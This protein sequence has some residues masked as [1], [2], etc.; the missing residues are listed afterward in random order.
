[1]PSKAL[2]YLYGLR[3]RYLLLCHKRN[4]RA[5]SKVANSREN[6]PTRRMQTGR[7]NAERV[8]PARYLAIGIIPVVRRLLAFFHYAQ[9]QI[10]FLQFV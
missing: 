1:M 3:S 2:N 5:T 7:G 10:L 9:L 4:V 6:P 8:A